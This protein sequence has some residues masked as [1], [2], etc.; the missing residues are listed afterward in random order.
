MR[1][2]IY[3]YIGHLYL[4]R[5][6]WSLKQSPKVLHRL[7]SNFDTTL[8][9][10]TRVFRYIGTPIS[11]EE[12]VEPE[13]ISESFYIWDGTGRDGMGRDGMGRD[14]MGRDGMGLSHS[15]AWPGRANCLY[16]QFK[17]QLDVLLL[18]ILYS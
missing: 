10:N 4:A 15:N 17:V 11:G 12:A 8:N 3:I 13:T 14:G 7:L 6:R 16:V 18:C 9:S 2:F 5:K 1:V